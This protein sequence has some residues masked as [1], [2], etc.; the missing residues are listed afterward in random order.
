MTGRSSGTRSPV[1]VL[2]TTTVRF[3]TVVVALQK[4]RTARM[5]F[6]LF[7]VSAILSLVSRFQVHHPL[8]PR[9]WHLLA[10]SESVAMGRGLGAVDIELAYKLGALAREPEHAASWNEALLLCEKGNFPPLCDALRSRRM[11][12][13]IYT[14]Q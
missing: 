4:S 5:G 10:A 14:P 3:R 13:D 2:K 9:P 12:Q 8:S 6:S 11:T 7:L 1:S